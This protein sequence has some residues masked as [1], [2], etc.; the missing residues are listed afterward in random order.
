MKYVSEYGLPYGVHYH[1]DS[2]NGYNGCEH[3]AHVHIRGKDC[4]VKYSL[5]TG[6][7]MEGRF[8]SADDDDIESWVN[9]NISALYDEWN[10]SNDP[11]GGR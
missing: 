8:G 5:R 11:A 9:H 7:Y 2:H 3:E 4:D 10:A 1:I 6:R